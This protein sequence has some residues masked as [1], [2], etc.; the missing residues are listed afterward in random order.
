M[1]WYNT[2]L[3]LFRPSNLLLTWDNIQDACLNVGYIMSMQELQVEPDKN[4][5]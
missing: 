3:I 1:L 4:L 5:G 2:S